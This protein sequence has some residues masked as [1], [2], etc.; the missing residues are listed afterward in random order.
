[1]RFLIP[2]LLFLLTGLAAGQPMGEREAPAPE[3]SA[4][5]P[6]A[7]SLA[8]A[9]DERLTVWR[10]ARRR[11]YVRHCRRA[12]GGCRAR[13]V[14]FS[15]VIVAAAQRHAVDPFL[16]A[17]MAL[18]ESGL[19]PFAEGSIGERGLVQLHP[20]GVGS[21]VRFVRS[22]GYRRRCERDEAACQEE[23]LDVGARLVAASIERCG[24]VEEGLGCYNTG[25]CQINA[26]ARRVLEERQNLLQLAKAD[27]RVAQ[28]A[29]VD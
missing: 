22:E 5:G 6:M 15:R 17:A 9:L 4:A 21:R 11:V 2:C 3:D 20:R 18:R 23:V 12:R 25:R 28:P 13:L 29:L 26:Y 8:R 1:M 24:S 14:A 16:V 27:I 19:N 10:S 7:V